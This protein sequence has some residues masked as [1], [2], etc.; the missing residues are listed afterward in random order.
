MKNH[1]NKFSSLILFCLIIILCS[2]GG[3]TDN[4]RSGASSDIK[5]LSCVVLLPTEIPYDDSGIDPLKKEGL[6]NGADFLDS[7]LKN[8]LEHSRVPRVVN[9]S[10]LHQHITEISGGM[11]GVIKVIGERANCNTALMTIL[12]KFNQRQGG[13]YAVDEAA[14]TAFELRLV[15]ANTGNTLWNATFNETQTSLL[16]NLFAFGKAKSRGFKWIT[17]EELAAQGIE[18]KVKTCP[19]LF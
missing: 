1:S 19:Y 12:S 9:P 2:C 16:S 7:T 10:E 18:E 17:V 8:M 5:P 15:E 4:V 13:E 3:K 11:R 14:S 6:R